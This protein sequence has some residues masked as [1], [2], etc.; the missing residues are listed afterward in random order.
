M[1]RNFVRGFHDALSK[2][3]CQALIE[4]FESEPDVRTEEVNR[5]TRNDKQMWLPD[6]SE[7]YKPVQKVKK[8]YP[9]TLNSKSQKRKKLEIVSL[10]IRF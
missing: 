4:W 10:N 2:E 7:L 6:N 8:P 1:L 5:Q 3:L 9:S